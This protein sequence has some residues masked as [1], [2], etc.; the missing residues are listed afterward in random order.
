VESY[1]Y[2]AGTLVKNL[3]ASPSISNVF[4]GGGVST[5][6]CKGTPFKLSL[7][8]S[9]KPTQLVWNLSSVLNIS[10]NANVTQVN[11][12]PSDSV[13]INGKKFYIYTLPTQYTFST[14]GTF[15]IPI[16]VFH[17][18][19]EGCSG[20]QEVTLN[21][22]VIAAPVANFSTT[23]SGCVGDLVQFNG[24]LTTT[25]GVPP[26]TWSWN[27]GD[28]TPLSTLQNPTHAYA[29]AGTYNVSL[30]GIAADGCVGDTT[31]PV[32][33]N[34]RPVVAIVQDT[35]YVC[36]NASAQFTVQNPVAGVTYNW[37]L[38]PT[39]GTIQGTGTTFTLNNVTGFVNVYLEGVQSGCSSTTR[40]RAT[41]GVLPTLQN[42]VAIVDSIGTNLLRFR[43]NAVAGTTGYQVSTN[44]G[45]TWITPSSGPFGL[46]HTITGLNLGTSV[47]LLVRALGGC[48]PAVSAP[49]T[50][51]T[52]TD[53]VYI[54]NS[55][56]P[57][58]DGL[59]DVFRVYSNVIRDMQL[60]VFNQWGEKI[61]ESNNPTIGWDGTHKNKPQPSGV[62]IY[63]VNI[64]LT[65]GEKI[66]RKGAVNLVR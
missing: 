59:N 40:D 47:T 9:V 39:G 52:R 26:A 56:S 53:Q 16:N 50:G 49:V 61:F 65:N 3:S 12:T 28:A 41:A 25:N 55:F 29:T 8:I 58:N 43:W 36:N 5:Y 38:V 21:V 34:P 45:T 31:K 11:P 37:Y 19:I 1:G 30:R 46:T 23:F 57:N 17:P 24:S 48:L 14:T 27:F 7:Q 54:P 66:Q 4:S 42:P 6:T 13:T 22:N 44:G 32:V 62:Y 64:T 60:T 20:S 18:S 35:I 51:Q 10:P 2:N 33:V 15:T 63:V